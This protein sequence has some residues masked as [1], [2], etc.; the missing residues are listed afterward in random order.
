M[1]KR[2]RDELHL[3]KTIKG[4]LNTAIRHQATLAKSIGQLPLPEDF[5]RQKHLEY[6]RVGEVLYETL[7]FT[8][9]VSKRIEEVTNLIRVEAGTTEKDY[10]N[11]V[12]N[13]VIN[14]HM[15]HCE[16]VFE[17]MKAAGAV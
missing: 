16:E 13:K 17:E 14:D 7:L 6:D 1:V 10:S 3:L 8:A 11:S 2:Y 9:T 12:A 4:Q 15:A 5:P